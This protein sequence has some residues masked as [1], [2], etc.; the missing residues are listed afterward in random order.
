MES[1]EK[2]QRHNT[3]STTN[4]IFIVEV[5]NKNHVWFFQHLRF[6]DCWEHLLF[7]NR[8]IENKSNLRHTNTC[9]MYVCM[10]NLVWDKE[11]SLVGE[12]LHYV[13]SD[14]AIC[15]YTKTFLRTRQQHVSFNICQ[16][17]RFF[18]SVILNRDVCPISKM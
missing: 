14:L 12:K 18:L 5:S 9:V 16:K 17:V 11:K 10:Y 8:G 4:N 1:N 3:T 2:K 6:N 13:S 15:T 7:G